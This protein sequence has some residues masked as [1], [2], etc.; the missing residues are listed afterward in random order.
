MEAND[1]FSFSTTEEKWVL[2][3]RSCYWFPVSRTGSSRRLLIATFCV[4][5]SFQ[6]LSEAFR[7][8]LVR[9]KQFKIQNEDYIF[10]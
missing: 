3:P 10:L 6:R 5:F 4:I 1:A 7:K 2:L 8:V 9:Y